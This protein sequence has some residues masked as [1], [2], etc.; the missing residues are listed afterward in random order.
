MGKPHF[1]PLTRSGLNCIVPKCEC[2]GFSWLHDCKAAR[3]L[4]MTTQSIP[5]RRAGRRVTEPALAELLCSTLPAAPPAG[6]R[7][8]SP[9]NTCT[10]VYLPPAEK[11]QKKEQKDEAEKHQ[12]LQTD[13]DETRAALYTWQV[14]GQ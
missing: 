6:H 8:C 3:Q 4:G 13:L 14:G 12:A 2:F 7:C 11:K 9:A 10:Y 1:E 5:A